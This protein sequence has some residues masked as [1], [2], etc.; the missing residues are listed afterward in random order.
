MMPIRYPL[1]RLRALGTE[2]HV[3]L[4][5]DGQRSRLDQ[6]DHDLHDVDVGHAAL[7]ALTD[8]AG[9]DHRCDRGDLAGDLAA[10]KCIG[11]YQR[12]LAK[13]D[14]AKVALVDFRAHTQ[15]G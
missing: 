2:I 13:L 7:S 15:L 1:L 11:A 14:I 8:A 12:H 5:A 6:V 4:H 9:V 3:D 10:T